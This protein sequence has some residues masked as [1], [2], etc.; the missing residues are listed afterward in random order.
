MEKSK[1][2]IRHCMLYEY[3]LG[4]SARAAAFNINT[5]THEPSVSHATISN[6][7][8]R[9]EENNYELKDEPRS[10][11]PLEVDLARLK[12]L[13]MQDPKQTTRCLASTLG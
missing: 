1:T 9:F 13:I 10:G 11:R 2:H 6:W 4:H 12:T 5:A 7:F 8:K 3:Q